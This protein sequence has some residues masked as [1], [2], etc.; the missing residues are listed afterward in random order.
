MDDPHH[1][2]RRLLTSLER[3]RPL[4][5]GAALQHFRALQLSP[6]HFRVLGALW[7]HSPLAMKDL[8]GN[9]SL[10]PPSVTALIR[11]LVAVGLVSRRTHDADSRIALIELTDKG[12]TLHQNLTEAQL[13]GIERLLGALAPDEQETMIG[14]LERAVGAIRDQACPQD[15]FASHRNDAEGAE[16]RG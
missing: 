15:P 3:M 2:A 16:E 5:M 11:H 7:H 13:E 6:S 10:T 1:N 14:L 9:L 12:Q 8:A 4:L